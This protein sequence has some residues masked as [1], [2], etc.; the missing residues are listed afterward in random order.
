MV[1]SILTVASR[2]CGLVVYLYFL[3]EL[4]QVNRG[5]LQPVQGDGLSERP[6]IPRGEAVGL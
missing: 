6:R 3:L 1:L 4:S 5:F 2:F